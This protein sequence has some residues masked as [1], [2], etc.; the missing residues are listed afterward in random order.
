MEYKLVPSPP[1]EYTN[2]SPL[3]EVEPSLP[4]D[5]AHRLHVTV[6]SRIT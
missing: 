6:T 4:R 1:S 5:L 3:L 2:L